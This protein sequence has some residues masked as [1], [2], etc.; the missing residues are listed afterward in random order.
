MVTDLFRKVFGAA[1]LSPISHSEDTP[2]RTYYV[3]T[4]KGFVQ[5]AMRA[6]EKWV[7]WRFTHDPRMATAFGSFDE[8]DTFMKKYGYT[9]H[10]AIFVPAFK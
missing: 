1:E 8:A 4:H 3:S 7:H 2:C 5:D 10:Y 6:H 9:L